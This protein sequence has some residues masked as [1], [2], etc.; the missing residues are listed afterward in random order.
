MA[1]LKAHFSSAILTAEY[2]AGWKTLLQVVAPTN[3]R[4]FV[5]SWGVY[6]KGTVNS[7]PAIRLRLIKQSDAGTGGTS[8]TASKK[9]PASETVQTAA[10]CG[11]FSVEPTVSGEPVDEKMVHPQA[12]IEVPSFERDEVVLAG[13][14]RIAIQYNNESG[15]TSV[16]LVADMSIEE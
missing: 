2:S 15:G 8:V 11:T 10:K 3:Q 6:C 5:T 16:P 7:D 12:G 4:V 9:I 13:G 14:D 1:G